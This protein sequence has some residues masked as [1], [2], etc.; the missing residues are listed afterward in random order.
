MPQTAPWIRQGDCKS[1]IMFIFVAFAAI[2][3][4]STVPLTIRV[5]TT[6]KK[7][8]GLYFWSLLATT[9]G[10]CIRQIGFLAKSVPGSCPWQVSQVLLQIGWIAMVTGFSTVLYSRL[11]IISRKRILRRAILAMIVSNGIVWHTSM[12]VISF[13]KSWCK[14][15]GR[16]DLLKKWESVHGPFE[17][18]QILFF[19]LQETIIA[20]T[21]IS[22]AY[23]YLK[24]GFAQRRQKRSAM[25]LLILVQI[26]VVAVDMAIILIDFAGYITLKVSLLS[27]AYA[28]KL[29][30]EFVVLN[31]L[32]ELS[33]LGLPRV[34]PAHRG[35][36]LVEKTTEKSP[37]S[38]RTDSGQRMMHDTVQELVPLESNSSYESLHFITIPQALRY[39][40]HDSS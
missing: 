31:Q 13:G 21:Y 24:S 5:L 6:L 23:K 20:L 40:R 1:N 33:C 36:G 17:R 9:W 3:L 11:N 22:I 10:L 32:V 28:V 8:S 15:T 35:S 2:A 7:R 39:A 12:T 37:Y 4:W 26:V 19:T 18:C 14:D 30:L 38:P 34:V 27:F 29:E 25:I 16:R